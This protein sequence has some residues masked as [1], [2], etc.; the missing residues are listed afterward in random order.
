MRGQ[1]LKLKKEEIA[2]LKKTWPQ[3]GDEYIQIHK[4]TELYEFMLKS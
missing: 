2:Y 4:V 1:R 3:N